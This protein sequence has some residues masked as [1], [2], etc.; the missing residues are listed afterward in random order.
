MSTRHD[1]WIGGKW[2]PPAAG[3]YLPTTDPT[4]RRP[5]DEVAAGS[6]ADIDRAVDAARAAQPAWARLP[7]AERSELLHHVADAIDADADGLIDLER[8]STGKVPAQ[9]RMEVDMSAA[10]FRYYAG[11]VRAQHGRTIEQGAGSH[12]YTRLEPYGVVAVITPWNFPLNQACRAAAPALAAGNAVVV[13]PSEF[14]SPSTLHLARLAA[15]AGL[16]DG[17]LN[18]VTGSGPDA[19]SPLAAHPA[20]GRIAFTGSVATGRHL[21]TIAAGRLVPMTLELGGKSPIVA[22]ADADLDRVVAASVTAV[23]MNAGQ[24]CTATT[25]LVVE[26]SAHDEVVARVVD[27]VERLQPGVDYGPII[28]EAQYRKVLEHFEA[29]RAGGVELRTG[30]AA[31]TDGPAAPGRYVLPTVYAHV[32]PALP[33]AREE[34]FGP[35]LVTMAFADEAEALALAN[36]TEY[37]LLASVWSGDVARGL[38]LAEQ[39]DAGQVAVNGGPLTIETPLGGYKHSGYGREKGLEALHEYAQIKTISLALG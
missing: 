2:E 7:A 1:H 39:I 33:I 5:G 18:V 12:T 32:P 19:G 27:G 30:G 15:E 9:A 37:G 28:T 8:A 23:A 29:A 25:R 35:V 11:V 10:Y 26:A 6:A 21:A 36:D 16:P 31:V 17:L 14:T 24:V 4:T 38:R 34:I 13:K 3:T 22:F 20:V